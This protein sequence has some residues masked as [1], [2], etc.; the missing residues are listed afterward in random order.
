[1]YYFISVVGALV[2]S[3][4]Q[5]NWRKSICKHLGLCYKAYMSKYKEA[6]DSENQRIVDFCYR[7]N[8][9]IESFDELAKAS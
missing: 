6:A 4:L 3:D 2:L 7:L 9:F 5:L 8:E 1:M